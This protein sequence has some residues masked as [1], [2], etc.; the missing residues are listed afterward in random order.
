MILAPR[1]HPAP[2][3]TDPTAASLHATWAVAGRAPRH[4]AEPRTDRARARLHIDALY[5]S[6]REKPARPSQLARLVRALG[7]F[8]AALIDTTPRPLPRI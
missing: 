7:A 8:A 4:D 6:L 2:Y 1:S 3:G 5:P